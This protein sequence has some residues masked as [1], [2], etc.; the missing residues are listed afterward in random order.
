MT[1]K[2][3]RN[4]IVVCRVGFIVGAIWFLLGAFKLVPDPNTPITTV[5]AFVISYGWLLGGGFLMV[6]GAAGSH[7]A[8]KKLRKL[9]RKTR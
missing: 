2:E 3:L 6:V 7:E 1:K 9:R 5:I 8:N 4:E